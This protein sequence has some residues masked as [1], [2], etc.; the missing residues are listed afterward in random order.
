MDKMK[1]AV[2]TAPDQMEIREMEIPR[3]GDDEVLVQVK[4]VGVCGSDIHFFHHGK[5]GMYT[6]EPPY[7]LGHECAGVVV[8]VGKRVKKLKIN[9]RVAVEPGLYCGTCEYCRRGRYNLCENMAFLAT[10]PVP[11]A[12]CEYIAVREDLAYVLPD[13]ISFDEAAMIEPLSVG[14]HSMNRLNIRAG[15]RVMIMGAGP[16]GLAALI[17]A[18]YYGAKDVVEADIM[19]YRLE[20]AKR[21]GAVLTINPSE[22][23]GRKALQ[24]LAVEGSVHAGLE[25]SG[26]PDGLNQLL[27]TVKKGGRIAV[28]AVPG[29]LHASV[30]VQHIVD[31]EL[32]LY[33]IF[34]YINTY[35]TGKS[36]VEAMQPLVRQLVTHRFALDQA[37]EAFE[38]ARLRK[39]EC[40]K[41]VIQPT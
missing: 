10:P 25:M 1:A 38:F 11:G 13:S 3:Y 9:D 36:I 7:V 6:V 20:F 19:P 16:V 30:N 15:E 34:R 5:I 17:A 26:S 24:E 29:S 33:G 35:P 32:T 21:L 22:P 39:N 31:K 4:S 27:G 41:V 14:I 8:A 28:V 23:D 12:L 2:M 37:Q 18:Q 40:V